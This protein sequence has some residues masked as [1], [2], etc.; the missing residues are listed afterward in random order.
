MT[1]DEDSVVTTDCSD[2]TGA[3]DPEST[4]ASALF[5]LSE[6]TAALS[7]TGDVS[8]TETDGFSIAESGFL[9]VSET[10][11]PASPVTLDEDSVVTT[12]CSDDT[13]AIDPESRG[14]SAL[15]SLSEVTAALSVTGDV[16][17]TETDGFSIA[18]SRFLGVSETIAPASPVTL[19]EDSVVTTD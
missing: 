8:S 14:A 15:F 11:A 10:I 19:D 12:D 13:G 9:G 4:G 16:S 7:V 3:I 1:L 17:S 18:E 6:V 2:D 5:S